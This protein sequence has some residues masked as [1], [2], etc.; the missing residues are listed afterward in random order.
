MLAVT[1]AA[2]GDMRAM[3]KTVYRFGRFELDPRS[4]SLLADGEP[5]AMPPKSFECVAYLVEHRDRAVGRDEL[6]SAVWGN[7]EVSDHTLGQTLLRARQ[8]LGDTGAERSMIRTVSRFGYEWIAPVERVVVQV[9]DPPRGREAESVDAVPQGSAAAGSVAIAARSSASDVPP[10]SAAAIGRPEPVRHTRHWLAAVVAVICAAGVLAWWVA[11]RQPPQAQVSTLPADATPVTATANAASEP[12][13]VVL[14]ASVQGDDEP[15]HAWIRLGMMDYLANLIRQRAGQQVLPSD[16]VVS[17][18]RQ[19]ADLDPSREANHFSQL[20]AVSGASHVIRPRAEFADGRWFVSLEV[21]HGGSVATY[22]A[23]AASPLPAA[24]QA[25][26]QLLAHL[27]LAQFDA[28]AAALPHEEMLQR[29]DAALLLGQL[30]EASALISHLAPEERDDPRIRVLAGNV[31]VR[32]GRLDDADAHYRAVTDADPPVARVDTLAA[33]WMGR[34]AVALTRGDNAAAATLYSRSI[35]LLDGGIEARLLGRALAGRGAA[36]IGLADFDAGLADLGRGR[37]ELSRARD[38]IGLANLESNVGMAET[39]GGRFEQA[40]A[41]QDRA[42][43]ILTGFGIRDQL[44][45]TL[46]NKIYTQ[47]A[48]VDVQGA[49]AT[50]EQAMAQVEHLANAVFNR[51]IAAARTRALLTA[52]RLGDAEALIARYDATP[53]DPANSDSEFAVLR[54]RVLAERGD[55]AAVVVQS[56]ATLDRIERATD[57][58]GQSSL[59]EACWTVADAALRRGDRATAQRVRQQLGDASA[60]EQDLDRQALA[61][62]IDAELAV[63]AGDNASAM[64]AEALSLATRRGMS[65][66]GLTVSY[67]WLRQLIAAGDLAQ[68]SSVAGRLDRYADRDYDTARI[69]EALYRALGRTSLADEAARKVR[70]LAGDRDPSLPI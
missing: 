60:S 54:L 8:A 5:L 41:S 51:R 1:P 25:V 38:Q 26:S 33:A 67:A 61:L 47:L 70:A 44:V 48:L 55:Y 23:A 53:E 7:T 46:H 24:A 14:P 30:R 36:W 16:Q 28:A 27:G 18:E 20:L 9:A 69:T 66:G 31:A 13:F 39:L 2:G 12:L 58:S 65:G 64:Y 68:A 4:R 22:D 50:S 62:L 17:M 57:L 49:L 3:Q 52:G 40:L 10:E 21:T 11:S 59:S 34:G 6:I 43:R 35:D 37:I 45:V 56:D 29:I 19:Q 42:I 63:H 32:E 15:E